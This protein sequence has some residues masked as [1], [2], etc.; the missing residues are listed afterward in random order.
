VIRVSP[1]ELLLK[2]FRLGASAVAAAASDMA[3]NDAGRHTEGLSWI[4]GEPKLYLQSN[5][6]LDC[7]GCN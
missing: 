2:R 6:C 5:A 1:E 4:K 3:L 7:P